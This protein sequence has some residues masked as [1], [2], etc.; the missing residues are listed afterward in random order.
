MNEALLQMEE[1]YIAQLERPIARQEE[2]IEELVRD[3]H[4]RTA[5]TARVLLTT[6]QNSLRLAREHADG[7]RHSNGDTRRQDRMALIAK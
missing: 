2:I 6:F 4:Q 1:R 3:S 5:E 7:S